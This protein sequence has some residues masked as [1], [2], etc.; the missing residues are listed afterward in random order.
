MPALDWTLT[1]A[2]GVTLVEVVVRSDVDRRVTVESTLQPV[3]PPRR[4]GRPAAGWTESGVTGVVTADDPLVVGYASPADPVDPPVELTDQQPVPADEAQTGTTPESM[5]ARDLLRMLGEAQPPR[6][7]VPQ[8]STRE[9]GRPEPSGG[10]SASR[11]AETA[12]TV[13]TTHAHAGDPPL[14][15]EHPAT[16]SP[17]AWFAG[18]ERRLDEAE[19]LSAVE[20]ADDGQ[21][22]VTAAGGIGEVRALHDQLA[23]DRRRVEAVRT[24][25]RELDARLADVEIPLATLERVA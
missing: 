7:A 20:S 5:E 10:V 11:T 25:C 3:W 8:H 24:R 18:V 17:E 6:D 9:D 2:D 23:A 22:A 14:S 4:H 12:E 13:E 19:R 1:R 21:E 16:E 15:E